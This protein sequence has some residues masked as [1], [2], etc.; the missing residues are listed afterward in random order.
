MSER[1]ANEYLRFV[2]WTPKLQKTPVVKVFSAHI[3]DSGA[4]HDEALLGHIKWFGRWR[5]FV[6]QP[7]P[8]TVF[9]VGC[10]ETIIEYIQS[11]MEE[12]RST[13]AAGS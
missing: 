3:I 2:E 12:R 7:Q 5:Q 9:N 4:G 10:M 11:L 1:P 8:L 6:F 13:T